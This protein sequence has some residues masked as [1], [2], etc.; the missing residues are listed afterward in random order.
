MV[1]LFEVAKSAGVS[2]SVAS[3]VLNGDANARISA[4]TAARV[5]AAA[6]RLR[7]VPNHQARSLRAARAGALGLLV[8]DVNNAVFADLFTGVQSAASQAGMTV[9]L[10]EMDR[11]PDGSNV[12]HDLVRQGRVDGVILQRAEDVDDATLRQMLSFDE[13]VVLFNSA[14]SRRPGSVTLPDTKAATM[15]TNHLLDLGHRRIGYIG[16]TSLHDAAKRRLRGFRDAMRNSGIRV[17]ADWVV[18][19]GWESTAGAAGIERLLA[20]RR[21]PTGVVVA[22]VNAALGAASRAIHAGLE[23]PNMLSIVSIQDTWAAEIFNPALTVVRMPMRRAGE[24]A[25]EMLLSVLAGQKTED[26]V[27][28]DPPPK[29]LVR[30]STSAPTSWTT[31]GPPRC[32][33]SFSAPVEC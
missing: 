4:D 17:D 29:L 10:G 13:P 7:Y 18:D 5:R 9:L 11:T 20:A 19:A 24:V 16:G 6:T 27:V 2:K 12:L 30:S 25:A 1:T 8:P 28:E 15:A 22:S 21:R 26:T 14:L 3:R 33:S 32:Q 23:L 31:Q